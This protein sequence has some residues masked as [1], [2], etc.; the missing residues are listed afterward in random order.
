LFFSRRKRIE[1][2]SYLRFGSANEIGEESKVF[3][4][5]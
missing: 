2:L 4:E 1:L 3:F 5:S